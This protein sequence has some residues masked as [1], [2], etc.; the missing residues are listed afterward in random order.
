[1]RKRASV[2]RGRGKGGMGGWAEGGREGVRES[3]IRNGPRY[4]RC[5]C[6]ILHVLAFPRWP[7]ILFLM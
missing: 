5:S 7:R 1:M 4:S 6:Y 3:L 2:A